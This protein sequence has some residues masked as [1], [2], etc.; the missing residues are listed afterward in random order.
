NRFSVRPLPFQKLPYDAPRPHQKGETI[1][2]AITGDR[3]GILWT[4]TREAL[5]RIDLK[6]GKYKNYQIHDVVSLAV[7][8]NGILWAG[9]YN[10][11]LTHLDP[12]T[13]RVKAYRHNPNDPESLSNN[14]A[15]RLLVDHSGTLWVATYDGL[16]RF[17]ALT[18]R[19]TTYKLDPKRKDL[20]YIELVED[21][22]GMLWLGTH[23][24]G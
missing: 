8:W 17:D 14:I 1:V 13:G 9:T 22:R 4:S 12:Q 18:E 15:T 6:T 20:L 21:G 16:N 2:N 7:D 19:F 11:G 3:Q 23:S 24:E 10:D 5:N